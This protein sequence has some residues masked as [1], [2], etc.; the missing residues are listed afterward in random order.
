MHSFSTPTSSR[1]KSRM[2]TRLA[3]HVSWIR[4]PLEKWGQVT[5]FLKQLS[6]ELQ[7]LFEMLGGFVSF[8]NISS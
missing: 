2:P 7:T 3:E 1:A 6:P 8:L 5:E 4:L